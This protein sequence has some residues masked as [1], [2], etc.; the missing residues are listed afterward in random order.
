MEGEGLRIISV[1]T[2]GVTVTDGT[3]TAIYVP[4][5]EGPSLRGDLQI[6]NGYTEAGWFMEANCLTIRDCNETAVYIPS[7][8]VSV[9]R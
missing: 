1:S 6:V 5:G 3:R 7:H 9:E 2:D 8:I 4:E